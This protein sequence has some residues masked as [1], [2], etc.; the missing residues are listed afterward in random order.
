MCSFVLDF[1][2]LAVDELFFDAEEGGVLGDDLVAQ[3]EVDDLLLLV[4]RLCEVQVVLSLAHRV[5]LG[6]LEGA[7][8]AEVGER[9]D[10]GLRGRF[11]V[12]GDCGLEGQS[13]ARVSVGEGDAGGLGELP[14][15]SEEKVGH[16]ALED[17]GQPGGVGHHAF[18]DCV[19]ELQLH[20]ADD[21]REGVVEQLDHLRRGLLPVPDEDGVP[22]PP[23]RAL[24]HQLPRHRTANANRMYS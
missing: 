19:V 14:A 21:R 22:L 11:G 2:V 17:V 8:A 24:Q 12:D 7:D 16:F 1:L 6:L 18:D 9:V 4:G 3:R 15:E 10:E 13:V 5:S 23:R 20:A